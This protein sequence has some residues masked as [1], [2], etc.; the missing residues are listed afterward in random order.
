MF[1]DKYLLHIARN[2]AADR[3]IDKISPFGDNGFI[4]ESVNPGSDEQMV[5]NGLQKNYS[6][7]VAIP[8]DTAHH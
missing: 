2:R 8:E 5:E 3:E 1:A 6:T 4:W 7:E